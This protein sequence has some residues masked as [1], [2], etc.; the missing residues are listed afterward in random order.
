[1]TQ[2]LYTENRKTGHSYEQ[3]HDRLDFSKEESKI[4]RQSRKRRNRS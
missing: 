3:T 1:M 2:K 4:E